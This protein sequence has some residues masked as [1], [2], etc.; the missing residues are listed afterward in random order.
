MLRKSGNSTAVRVSLVMGALYHARIPR[1][2]TETQT[3]ISPRDLRAVR[4]E[5]GACH[6]KT[7]LPLDMPRSQE[8]ARVFSTR[9]KCAHCPSEW[10]SHGEDADYLSA[11]AQLIQALAV[12]QARKDSKM[13]FTLEVFPP[14]TQL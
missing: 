10:F 14:V 11:I 2:T 8:E 3:F 6:A 9:F 4:I 12:I 5:C 7:I 13:S 1:M